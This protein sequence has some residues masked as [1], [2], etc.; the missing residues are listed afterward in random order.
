MTEPGDRRGGGPPVSDGPAGLYVHVPFCSGK[1]AYCDFYSITD[2]ARSGE[3]LECV[4]REAEFLGP[5]FPV[6]DTLYLGGG[7]PSL[8]DT[9]VLTALMSELRNRLDFA[10]DIEVTMEVNPEDVRPWSPAVYRSMGVTRVSM[11][12]QSL[13]D[14][15]LRFLGRRHSASQALAALEGLLQ[16]GFRSVGVDLIYGIPGLGPADW[17]ETLE[18]VLRQGPQHISCY[19][20]TVSP[21]TPL[22]EG[23]ASGETAMPEED[24]LAETFL[25]TSRCLTSRGFIHYEVSNY[26]RPGHES[27]HNLKYWRRS[28]YLGLGPGA[29]SFKHPYRWWNPASLD[30]CTRRLRLN[31]APWGRRELLSPEQE[32]LERLWLGFRTLDGV[33]ARDF[34]RTVEGEKAALALERSGL[35]TREGSRLVPTARGFLVSDGLPLLFSA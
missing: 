15:A 20:L 26:A 21:G 10:G 6:F 34:S 18:S 1:C 11:G 35:V 33:E 29:H 3:W 30:A 5:V 4:C 9:G 25:A 32:L 13:D 2:P 22:A 27:R 7:T 8:L 17:M 23:I 31:H 19:E 14:R 16:A 12:I 28:P 24:E